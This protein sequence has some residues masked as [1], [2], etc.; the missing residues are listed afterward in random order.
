[1]ASTFSDIDRILRD[2]EI[3]SHEDRIRL[4]GRIVETVVPVRSQTGSQL[5][6]GEFNGSGMSNEEDFKIAEWHLADDAFDG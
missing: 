5:K 6:Y 3:L 4:I 1:M 2:I